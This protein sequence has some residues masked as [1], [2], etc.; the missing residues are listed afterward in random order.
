MNK[1]KLKPRPGQRETPNRRHLHHESFVLIII[2]PTHLSPFIFSLC[3]E[4]DEPY[5]PRSASIRPPSDRSPSEKMR[6]YFLRWD[7]RNVS[8]AR[9]G[10][11]LENRNPPDKRLRRLKSPGAPSLA[12]RGLGA[13][14]EA[15]KCTWR[16]FAAIKQ[17]SNYVW[18]GAKTSPVLCCQNPELFTVVRSAALRIR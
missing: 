2:Q 12:S 16:H 14:R 4:C 5:Y 7:L 17:K 18:E 3:A 9:S 1:V 13:R 8:P 6:K 15:M 10:G 11:R